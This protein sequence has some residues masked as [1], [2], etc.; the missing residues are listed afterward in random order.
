MKTK[1]NASEFTKSDKVDGLFYDGEGGYLIK[2]ASALGETPRTREIYLND[3]GRFPLSEDDVAILESKIMLDGETLQVPELLKRSQIP[4]YYKQGGR[5]PV[6]IPRPSAAICHY[7]AAMWEV[8]SDD[9]KTLLAGMAIIDSF[10][11]GGT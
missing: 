11:G 1:F 10:V 6:Y 2:T 5:F 8:S 3:L 7:F 4:I 9:E